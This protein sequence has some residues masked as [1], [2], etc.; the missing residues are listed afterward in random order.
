M[1]INY[2]EN[3]DSDSSGCSHM[4]IEIDEPAIVVQHLVP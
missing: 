3:Y 2:Y 4:S 1:S